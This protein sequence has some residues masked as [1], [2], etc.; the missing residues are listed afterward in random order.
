MFIIMYKVDY[1]NDKFIHASTYTYNE[2]MR[3]FELDRVVEHG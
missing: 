3:L 1:N 2:V